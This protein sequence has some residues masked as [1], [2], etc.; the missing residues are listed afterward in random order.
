LSSV[1]I[2][3]PEIIRL[4]LESEVGAEHRA[5]KLPTLCAHAVDQTELITY[6]SPPSS[7]SLSRRWT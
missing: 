7:A 1:L 2:D 4:M 3:G 5:M 6:N